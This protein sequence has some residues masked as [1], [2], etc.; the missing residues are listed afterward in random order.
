MEILSQRRITVNLRNLG[1]AMKQV[2]AC[3]PK[4]NGWYNQGSLGSQAFLGWPRYRTNRRLNSL[5]RPRCGRAAGVHS[6]L[7]RP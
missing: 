4:Q 5:R 6:D 2:A 1:E 7:D 3:L